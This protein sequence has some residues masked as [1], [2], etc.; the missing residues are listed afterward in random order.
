MVANT[1]TY[2]DTPFHRFAD[3]HDLTDVPL[4]AVAG[5]PGVVVDAPG[6]VIGADAVAELDIG[7]KALILRT[8]WSQHWGK[9]RYGDVDHPHLGSDA[10]DPRASH[11]AGSARLPA[12]RRVRGASEGARHGQLPRPRLWRLRRLMPGTMRPERARRLSDR[13]TIRPDTEESP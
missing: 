9:P 11:R 8:G 4:E 12:L 10:V 3:G 7:G 1:G 13:H 6:P 5:V 2:L